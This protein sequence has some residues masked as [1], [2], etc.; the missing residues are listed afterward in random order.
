[1]DDS[2]TDDECIDELIKR[3]NPVVQRAVDA[4]AAAPV[5]LAT[6]CSPWQQEADTMIEKDEYKYCNLLFN[7]RHLFMNVSFEIISYIYLLFCF[8]ILS[9]FIILQRANM[10]VLRDPRCDSSNDD[11]LRTICY[12]SRT[13]KEHSNHRTAS[14]DDNPWMACRPTVSTTSRFYF[15]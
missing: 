1:M 10:S 6:V 14:V 3:N 8:I 4:I 2:D 5:T 11:G 13:K 12:P 15:I 9:P 7:Y